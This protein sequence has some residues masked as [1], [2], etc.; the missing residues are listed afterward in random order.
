MCVCVS[1]NDLTTGIQERIIGFDS[2][3]ERRNIDVMLQE[4]EM[5]DPL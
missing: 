3:L 2:A 4:E 1:R 5:V